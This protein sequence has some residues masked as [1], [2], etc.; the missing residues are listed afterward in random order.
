MRFGWVIGLVA[1]GCG[2]GSAV[3]PPSVVSGPS[4]VI[5]VDFADGTSKPEYDAA[6]SA[7]G[8]DV[9]FNAWDKKDDDAPASD[10]AP[11]AAATSS[12]TPTTTTTTT[13]AAA[14]DDDGKI[15]KYEAQYDYDAQEDNELSFAR[16]VIASVP[17]KKKK[18][19]AD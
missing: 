1:A 5:V 2:S 15:V 8:V 9:E 3:L 7:W 10:A 4:T 11:A 12:T 16:R 6:E 18:A 13:A 17:F 14:N 19:A